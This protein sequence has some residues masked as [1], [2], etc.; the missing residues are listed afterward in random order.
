VILGHLGKV[1]LRRK[2]GDNLYRSVVNPSDVNPQKNRFSFDF[3]AGMLTTGDL[4]EIKATDGGALDFVA[5]S[6][7]FTPGVYPDGKWF[8]H[9]DGVGGVYLYRSFDEAISGEAVGRADLQLPNRNIPISVKILDHIDRI[10][11]QVTDFQL[12]TSRDAV[13]VTELGTEFRQQYSALISGSGQLSCFFD[14]ERRRCDEL[15]AESS[16]AIE[17]PVYMHQLLLRTQLGSGFWAKLTLAGRGDKPGGYDVDFDDEVWTEFDALVTNVAIAFEATQP[18]RTT[19]DF[20]TTGE[21]RLRTRMVTNFIV[22]EQDGRSRIRME[23]MLG[24]GFLTLEE[25]QEE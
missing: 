15:S 2:T 17:M 25:G 7:W 8:C 21:I 5:P 10:I 11:G 6:G 16:G 19:I 24:N 14:Y 9:V 13:D 1:E 4:L 22:Q 23:E 12:N 3:P 18:V 20:V